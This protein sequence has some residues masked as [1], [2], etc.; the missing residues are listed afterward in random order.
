[1]L[2]ALKGGVLIGIGAATLTEKEIR[3]GVDELAR[4][5]YVRTG[6]A[7][8]IANQML[9][10]ARMHK[11]RL[12]RLAEAEAKRHFSKLDRHSRQELASLRNRIVALE[13]RLEKRAVLEARKAAADFLKTT[14]P[15][16]RPGKARK[17]RR[18]R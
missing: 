5:G 2:N 6:E 3:K 15:K 18:K 4:K 13:K 16:K 11:Q 1:M 8:K 14:A 9:K 12:Q 10:E 7:K 17:H